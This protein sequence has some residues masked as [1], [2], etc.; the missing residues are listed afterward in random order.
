V[1]RKLVKDAPT[2]DRINVTPIIGVALV[3]VLILLI[4]APMFAV[5]DL[6]IQLPRAQTR[7]QEDDRRV[8]IT[9][10]TTGEIAVDDVM[11]DRAD[12]VR[13]VATRLEEKKKQHR[14]VVVRADA[15]LPHDVVREVLRE[16]RE[17]G[18]QRLAIG[19]HQSQVVVP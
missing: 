6:G 9:I 18:A 2:I 7:G 14:L 11:I 8:S 10:S 5:V 12:L 19:T 16:A 1:K 17:A 13:A 4:T 3:L 15:S